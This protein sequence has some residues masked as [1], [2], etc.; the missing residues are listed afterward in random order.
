MCLALQPAIEHSPL[1]P[2]PS[3]V[4]S[5]ILCTLMVPTC[6]STSKSC[7]LGVCVTGMKSVVL[8]IF[9][10]CRACSGRKSTV[11][12]VLLAEEYASAL[13]TAHDDPVLCAV[14]MLQSL[15]MLWYMPMTWSTALQ[16]K[17]QET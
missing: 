12:S 5:H 6:I 8:C 17:V 2:V 16:E 1:V 4:L 15:G 11:R 9:S 14:R 10:S 13:C 7:S 3:V